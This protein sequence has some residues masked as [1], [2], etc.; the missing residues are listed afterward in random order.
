MWRV[1]GLGGKGRS[2]LRLTLSSNRAHAKKKGK[3]ARKEGRKERNK[4][5]K[6]GM[7]EKSGRGQR[8]RWVSKRKKTSFT[9][10]LVK[11]YRNGAV[12]ITNAYSHRTA[13]KPAVRRSTSTN[14]ESAGRVFQ[15]AD[16]NIILS[17]S[18]SSIGKLGAP[19]T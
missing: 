5:R 4:G 8:G 6:E 12:A 10:V 2:S 1:I 19:P 11:N 13:I 14:L 3:Q 17:P 9:N 16:P 18:S 7:T 15:A